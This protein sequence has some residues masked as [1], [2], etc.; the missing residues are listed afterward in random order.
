MPVRSSWQRK[1]S[2]HHGMTSNL[3]VPH[4]PRLP[5][6]AAMRVSMQPRSCFMRSLPRWLARRL[7]FQPLRMPASHR[8]YCHGRRGPDARPAL[9]RPG[10]RFLHIGWRG[11]IGPGEFPSLQSAAAGE[12]REGGEGIGALVRS[13]RLLCRDGHRRRGSRK[14]ASTWPS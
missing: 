13:T 3:T 12:A 4:W 8:R 5:D 9:F 6:C 10:G 2:K 7:T 14:R 1:R 11:P